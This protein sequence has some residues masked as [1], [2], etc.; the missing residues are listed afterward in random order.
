[1][2]K[3]LFFTSQVCE[4]LAR[5]LVT[6]QAE[7]LKHQGIVDYIKRTIIEKK[8]EV[9]KKVVDGHRFRY[10]GTSIIVLD[11]SS[12]ESE[13]GIFVM[14]SFCK[15]A[16]NLLCSPSKTKRERELLWEYQFAFEHCLS[17]HD[18]SWEHKLFGAAGRLK[19]L[20]NRIELTEH[21]FWEFNFDEACN[22]DFFK[23]SG[24]D[25]GSAPGVGCKRIML[26]DVV[27]KH[28]S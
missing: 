2:A 6:E 18:K 21:L 4:Q 25:I 26:E 16:N 24:I 28:H 23:Q 19:G 22:P 5:E 13:T 12:F 3:E 9:I 27:I 7:M 11:V 8:T 17:E 10:Q 15:D 1:M 14:M 20:K